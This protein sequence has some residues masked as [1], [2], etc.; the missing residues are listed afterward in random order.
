M[1]YVNRLTDWLGFAIIIVVLVIA[2]SMFLIQP[3]RVSGDSMNPTLWD[4]Q[5]IYISKWI[6][7]YPYVPAYGEIVIIDSRLHRPR[8]FNDDVIEWPIYQAL[9]RHHEKG[10]I[11][12]KRVIGRPGDV[13][14]FKNNQVYRN[15]H[16]LKEPYIKE[17]MLYE[18]NEPIWVPK[19]HVFVMGDNR[20][21]SRDSREIGCIPIDHLIGVKIFK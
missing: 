14:E 18:S 21:D 4:Q 12:I 17:T 6:Q 11:W 9:T 20:N 8:S 15:G 19:D 5:R 2:L 13:L 7:I 16:V 3:T 1:K 10:H